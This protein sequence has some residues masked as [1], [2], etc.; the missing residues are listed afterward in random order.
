MRSSLGA[1]LLSAMLAV[2]AVAQDQGETLADIR[3]Q[4]S[5]LHV[6][7]QRLKR[8]LSTTGAPGGSAQG[9]SVLARVDAI[10]AELQTLTGRVEE[11]GFRVEQV[12]ETGS[13][14]VNDLN[15]RLCELEPNCNIATL[16]DMPRLGGTPAAGGGT[17]ITAPSAP[18]S[19]VQ[20][21]PDASELAVGEQDDFDNASLAM[22]EQRYEDAASAFGRFVETYP[23]SPLTAQAQLGRAQA[24]KAVGDSRESARAYL[25][26]FSADPE[27]PDAPEALTGLG[28]ALGALGQQ[29]EACLTLSEVGMRFPG[30]DAEQTAASEMSS[31]GCS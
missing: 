2:P 25:A 31:L 1:L 14:R 4:L 24:L 5:V 10:E 3:Q 9:G 21:A 15:F 12:V 17:Q 13:N 30:S 26:A 28:A 19:P 7:I 8:E 20:V 29:S 6:D 11:L 22:S 18:V 23:G 27:G 16:E